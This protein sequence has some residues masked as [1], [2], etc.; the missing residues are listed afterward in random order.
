MDDAHQAAQGQGCAI[1]LPSLMPPRA[2]S[3]RIDRK[4]ARARNE[5]PRSRGLLWKIAVGK[6]ALSAIGFCPCKWRK[7]FERFT[8]SACGTLY[9]GRR[10]EPTTRRSLVLRLRNLDDET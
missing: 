1:E 5:D 7:F 3:T 4:M 6:V 9:K 8:L 10:M 2:K